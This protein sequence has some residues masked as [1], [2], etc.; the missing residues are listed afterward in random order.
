[1]AY[2]DTDFSGAISPYDAFDNELVEF[3]NEGCD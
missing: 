2:Y 1:M 3:L